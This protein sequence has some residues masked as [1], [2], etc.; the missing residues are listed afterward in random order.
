[1]KLLDLY[2]GAGGATRGY[3]R[4]GFEVTGID[5]KPQPNY[6]GEAFIQADALTI[7][8]EWIAENFDAV[9]ASPPCQFATALRSAPRAKFH[10]NLIP[11]TKALL[12]ET[13]L[14]WILENVESR[15]TRECMRGAFRLCGS[16]F[17]LG[18]EGC[19]LRRH[20]L[21]LSNCL[22]FAQPCHHEPGASVIGVY[23]GHARKRAASKGG[24]RTKEVWATSHLEAAS[25]AMGIDW[26]TLAEMSEAIPPEFT[27]YLGNQLRRFV[28]HR[29][30]A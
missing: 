6:C 14:P 26:M 24:R 18:A 17:G 11:E 25:T 27:K 20:R 7:R 2:C 5:I 4:A 3:Q 30:V 12:N 9:H 23:G 28:A 15:L 16:S 13:R 10:I 8:P 1:M 29:A 21:F 22:L 19:S